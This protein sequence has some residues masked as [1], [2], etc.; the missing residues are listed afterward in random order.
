MKK[1]LIIFIS[2]LVLLILTLF[3]GAEWWL[4]NNLHRIVNKKPDRAYN[5]IYR[6]VDIHPFLK[7]I[8]LEGVEIKPINTNKKTLIYGNVDVAEV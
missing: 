3:F 1:F 6:D 7:G 2:V 5:I 8:S 4:T